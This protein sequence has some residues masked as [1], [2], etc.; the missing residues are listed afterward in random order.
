M[1]IQECSTKTL[2]EKIQ[3]CLQLGNGNIH[4]LPVYGK[5]EC[6]YFFFS[7]L[8][9]LWHTISPFYYNFK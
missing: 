2:V 3:I 4:P 5:L 1:N 6:V 8:P 7:I 9:L